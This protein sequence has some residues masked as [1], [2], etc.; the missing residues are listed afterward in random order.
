MK[1]FGYKT[2]TD[3]ITSKVSQ[4]RRRISQFQYIP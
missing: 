2:T 1:Q 3:E 4:T